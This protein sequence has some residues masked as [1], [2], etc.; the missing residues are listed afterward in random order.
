MGD[1]DIRECERCGGR[2]YGLSRYAGFV[3]PL[4]LCLTCCLDLTERTEI[5]VMEVSQWD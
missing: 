1:Y 4:D 5:D 2:Y 3:G